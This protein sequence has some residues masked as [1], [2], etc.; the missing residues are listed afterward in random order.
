MLAVSLIIQGK[1]MLYFHKKVTKIQ[2]ICINI[3][4]N[5]QLNPDYIS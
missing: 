4:S 2:P 1:K 3:I 5:P